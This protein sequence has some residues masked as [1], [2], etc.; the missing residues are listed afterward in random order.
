MTVATEGPPPV[1]EEHA[2]ELAAAIQLAADYGSMLAMPAWKDLD[3]FMENQ[4][5]DA[6]KDLLD[7]TDVHEIYRCQMV[8]K[9]IGGIRNRI[10]GVLRNAA[11]A[12]SHKPEG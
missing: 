2:E 5:Q 7:L 3:A 11:G 9:T 6:V 1:C 12:R 8:I 4:Y 10:E